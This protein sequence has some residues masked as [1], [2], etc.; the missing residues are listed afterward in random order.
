MRRMPER[1][2]CDANGSTVEAPY[3]FVDSRMKLQLALATP[4]AEMATFSSV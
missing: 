1:A 4:S 2:K 3:T